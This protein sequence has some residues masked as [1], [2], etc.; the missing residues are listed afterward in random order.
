MGFVGKW[1]KFRL[2]CWNFR[3]F[4]AN[5]QA[6][7]SIMYSGSINGANFASLAGFVGRIAQNLYNSLEIFAKRQSVNLGNFACK[8]KNEETNVY[9]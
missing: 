1:S 6:S 3:E 7:E 9:G 4:F 8:F 5:G 2:I